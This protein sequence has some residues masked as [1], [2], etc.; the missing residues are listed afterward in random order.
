MKVWTMMGAALVTFSM[1]APARAE[2][3]P[4]HAADLQRRLV[5]LRW[6][7][8]ELTYSDVATA[9]QRDAK[10]LELMA[11]ESGLRRLQSMPR[12]T[13]ATTRGAAEQVVELPLP[14]AAAAPAVTAEPSPVLALPAASR[15]AVVTV[16]AE[17]Q[18]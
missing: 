9:P 8:H 11:V 7:L 13:A 1:L 4:D 15:V 3:R 10:R 14:P 18:T 16:A 17:P 6:E 5:D 12:L 2:T